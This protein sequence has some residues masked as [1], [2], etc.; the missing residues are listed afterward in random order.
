MKKKLWALM[1]LALMASSANAALICDMCEDGDAAGNYLGVLNG[2][3]GDRATF[4]NDGIGESLF[5]DFWV[6][7][8]GPVGGRGIAAASF[9]VETFLRLFR[10]QL[11]TDDGSQCAAGIGCLSVVLGDL[12]DEDFQVNRLVEIPFVLEPGR[13]VL[14]LSGGTVPPKEGGYTGFIGLFANP[15]HEPG[16]FSLLVLGLLMLGVVGIRR[17]LPRP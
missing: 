14:R 9:V 4:F 13:Y 11:W 3:T 10:A 1:A 17:K 5:V 15:I 2:P 12:I 7:D 8:I 6:F 16:A